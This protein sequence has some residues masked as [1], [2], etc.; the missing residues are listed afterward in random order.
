LAEQLGQSIPA[1]KNGDST[2]PLSIDLEMMAADI[3]VLEEVFHDIA[4]ERE[5]LKVELRSPSRVT[6][7]ERAEVPE[8]PD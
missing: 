8:E 6:L 2:K 1:K 5:R 3:R 4:L 7:L